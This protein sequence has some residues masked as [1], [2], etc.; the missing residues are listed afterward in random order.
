MNLF[1]GLTGSLGPLLQGFMN[2]PYGNQQFQ[3]E[4]QLGTSQARNLGQTATS[5]LLNN[6]IGSGMAG[7]A[8]NPAMTEMLQNQARA[9][10]GL[11]ANLGFLAPTQAAQQRQFRAMNLA[12]AYRPLQTGQQNVQSTQGLGTLLPQLLNAGMG[13]AGMAAG[14]PPGNFF[15]G[16]GNGPNAAGGSFTP[17]ANLG[18]GGP[19]MGG[20]GPTSGNP[21]G[22]GSSN[23]FGSWMGAGPPAPPA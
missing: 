23:P 11:Q 17:W 14:M 9:N 2:N 4:Q 19:D 20:F 16:A 8:S 3:T 1:Q 22:F 18:G 21:G 7:G 6:A 5:G 12:A 13:I 15:A 10:T